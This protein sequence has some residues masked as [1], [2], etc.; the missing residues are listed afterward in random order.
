MEVETSS[1]VDAIDQH[2]MTSLLDLDRG[3]LL[4]AYVSTT[5]GLVQTTGDFTTVGVQ[6]GNV[7]TFSV[8]NGD[9]LIYNGNTLFQGDM[10]D[11]SLAYTPD[12]I[13][14]VLGEET[15]GSHDYYISKSSVF[16]GSA[17]WVAEFNG[18]ELTGPQFT[19]TA[20]GFWLN[21]LIGQG[22]FTIVQIPEPSTHLLFLAATFSGLIQRKR[23]R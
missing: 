14:G 19:E 18:T 4:T 13:L 15:S 23:A 2:A 6:G 1:C 21:D 12:G 11:L 9:E 7:M 10:S 16:T 20:A 22:D 8:L 17:G 5:A 3:V